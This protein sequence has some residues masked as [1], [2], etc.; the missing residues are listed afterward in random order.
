MKTVFITRRLTEESIFKKKLEQA[1]LKVSGESLLE[2][3]AVPF[4][5]IPKTDWIFFYSKNGVRF[6]FEEVELSG[7]AIPQ[8]VK[9]AAIGAETAGFLT[10]FHK[11]PDFTGTGDPEQTALSFSKIAKGQSALF[12]R[13]TNSRRS[14]QQ[15][16]GETIKA[17]DLIVYKN[18]PKKKVEILYSDFVVF[19]SPMNAWV[20][21][22][23]R[24]LQ[25]GQRLFVIGKT[26]AKFLLETDIKS[27]EIAQTPSE[28]G[29]AEAILENLRRKD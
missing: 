19:T 12:P 9:W 21:L 18:V 2:F 25:A 17:V 16:L 7:I 4:D 28:E 23:N 1:G 3:S 20:Y 8:N 5:K 10:S 22:E 13:A 11:T 24:K 6:F 15:F 26:T 27:F 14:V 29:L